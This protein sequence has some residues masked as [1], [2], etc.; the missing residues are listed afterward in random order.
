MEKE[1]WELH[2]NFPTLRESALRI[3]SMAAIRTVCRI[4]SL[5]LDIPSF[6][7]H[8][9]HD[10]L[11]LFPVVSNSGLK[12]TLNACSVTRIWEPVLRPNLS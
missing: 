7:L 1:E 11:N 8:E 4:D 6:L 12:L 5:V 10:K 3:A 2:S 9:V